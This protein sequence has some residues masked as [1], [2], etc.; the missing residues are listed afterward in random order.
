MVDVDSRRNIESRSFSP[1]VRHVSLGV[2]RQ[3]HALLAWNEQAG[4]AVMGLKA[5]GGRAF[6][7][8]NFD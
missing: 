3:A 6:R 8:K 5:G 7:L 4:G 1:P 2:A